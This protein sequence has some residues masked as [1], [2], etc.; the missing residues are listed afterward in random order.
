MNLALFT[1]R[2]KTVDSL[3]NQ[4]GGLSIEYIGVLAIIA[5]AIAVVVA[6]LQAGQ[7]Q[8]QEL[9]TRLIAGIG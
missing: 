1:F 7:P 9:F 8:I 2:D 6:V 5:I 3:R 4:R